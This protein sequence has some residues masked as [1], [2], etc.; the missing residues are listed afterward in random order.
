MDLDYNLIENIKAKNVVLFLGSGFAFNAKH[1]QNKKPPLGQELAKLISEYFLNGEYNNEPLTFVS[2]MAINVSNL[3]TVQKF[4][5]EL[6]QD[7]SPNENHLKFASLP[8]KAIFTTNYDLILEKAYAAIKDNVQEI[9]PVFRNTP[10][11]QIFKSPTSVPYYKLHGCISYIN[12]INL[13]LILSTEQYV[14]HK[15]NRDR[16][17]SKLYELAMDYSILFIGYS[18]QDINIRTILKE[19]ESLKD[20]K[21]RSYMVKPSFRSEEI[22]FWE[23][24]KIKPISMG[25]EDFIKI[26]DSKI[27]LNDRKLSNLILE[28]E[29]PIYSKFQ[30]DTNQRSPTQSLINLLDSEVD[31]VHSSIPSKE[32]LPQHFYKGFFENWDPIIKN[33]DV[34]RSEKDRLLT[35]LIFEE[36][37]QQSEKTYFFVLKGHAGSGKSVLLKRVAWESAVEFGK[38]C[39]FFKNNTVLRPEPILELFNYVKERLYIFIENASEHEESIIALINI[40]NKEKIPLT[41]ISSERTNVWNEELVI[42]NYITDAYP[43]SY[44][45]S[46]EIDNLIEKLE[47]HNSLGFLENKNKAQR[48]KELSEKAGRVLLVAL[49]EATGGKAFEEIILDEYNQIRDEQA[50]ALYLTVSILHRLGSDARAGL[51]SRVHGINFNEFKERLYKPLEL[52]VFDERNYLINDFVYKTR[53]PY[54]AEIIFETV[55]KTEQERYDEYVRILGY[56]NIDYSSDLNAFLAMT[57]AKKLIE[58]FKDPIKVN[59]L[60]DIACDNNPD[61]P[62]LLQQRAVYEMNSKGGSLFTAEKYLKDALELLPKDVSITHSLAE[63]ALKKAENTSS[64]LERNNYLLQSKSLCESILRGNKDQSYTYHTLLK[65]LILRMKHA[66]YENDDKSLE[67]RIKET[68]KLLSAVKQLFPDQEFILEIESRFNEIIENEPKAINLLHQAWE[69][70]KASPYL[71]LRYA[72]TLE[73]ANDIGRALQ[74]LKHTIELVPNDRDLSYKYAQYISLLEPT[75]EHDIIHYY[76][77]S[78]TLGDTRYEAQFWYA[79][80]LY[81]FNKIEKAKEIFDVLSF[82]RLSPDKKHEV[83]GVIQNNNKI[84]EVFKGSIVRKELNFAIVRRDTYGDTIFIN[85]GHCKELWE[86]VKNNGT[87]AFHIGFNFKGPLGLVIA[88]H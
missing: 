42:K 76:R 48:K 12:D 27:T 16:L 9:S 59:N 68:E 28:V 45:S 80:A 51:I 74:V 35:N 19:I 10:E 8:W 24:K 18:N 25:H 65:I 40:A 37:Y 60:F 81:I 57:N 77:R 67:S 3:F 17:F 33:L 61:E 58:I 34:Q 87:I 62:K 14:D 73:R 7:F 36:K 1:P 46:Q 83:R 66:I 49:Y 69:L 4:I 22:S 6:F 75:N 30:V 41:I 15:V 72:K 31:Y 88:V 56:L 54:I 39:I 86:S 44:L 79:R 70:N 64:K 13:P 43:I 82:A 29:R 20:A 78:F 52:I 85:K 47:K 63:V 55:L 26:V 71:A 23:N 38:I 21:P 53:H 84:H 11:Q 50:K 5:A 2:E 32:T